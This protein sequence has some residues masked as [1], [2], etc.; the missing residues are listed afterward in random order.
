M[1]LDV[2]LETLAPVRDSFD[3]VIVDE[4][5]QA[6]IEDLFLLWL[7]PRV[8]VVGDDKQCAPSQ[9]RMGELE[10]IFSKLTSYL[11]DMPGYLRD[12]FTP[13]SSLFD[14]LRTRFGAVIPLR[15][16]FRCM[17]EII[18]FSSRQFYA[19]EPLVPL[20]QFGADRLPPLRA[21]K[22][23]GAATEGSSTRLRNRIEAEAIV[24]QL[25]ACLADPA[26]AGKTMGIVVLQGTGQVQLLHRM[27]LERIDP[28]EW[29][30]RRLR[31][32]TPPDF[33]GDERDI[34]M[35]SLVIAEKRA[36]VTGTEW[37]R[38]FNVAASRAKDQ[39]WL[40]HSVGL[41]Q[42][43]ATD[44]RAS[45]LSYVLNPPPALVADVL[46]GVT[47]EEP[48]PAFRSLFDQRVFVK[49]HERGF[50]VTP[51]VEVNGR[52]IDLVVT[53]ARGRLAVE[54]DG[55]DWVGTEV[56]R[57]ADLD[58]ERE[59][60]RAGW[61]FWRVRESEFA[62]DPDA[63]LATLWQTL[64][65]LDIAPYDP[66]DFVGVA[67]NAIVWRPTELSTVEGL[68]GLDGDAPEEL[69]DVHLALA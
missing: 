18:E 25:E 56:Q 9:V 12:A 58:R 69:D 63:A 60:K 20:R 1:P 23:E 67:S 52:H 53:G 31:V 33:Q 32:G 42:L 21:V 16:H 57:E 55:Q 30:Q 44:L 15:E 7:A 47:P 24:S 68:D 65:R 19:D 27:L 10:P 6:S 51:Q 62:F 38:R 45:L 59:L 29:E 35:V 28:K 41:D 5:S 34:I 66:A 14:L 39:L 11:P 61:R 37:Q 49:L 17:P 3:V 46:T 40:F 4:A 26:Y 43:S 22:V 36:A 50:H 13:K 54:C 2:V 64:D 48:H 8:I